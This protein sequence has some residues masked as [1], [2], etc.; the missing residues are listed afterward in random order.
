M[1]V[2]AR[3]AGRP[4]DL[5]AGNRTA[6]VV[7]RL[8]YVGRVHL[9]SAIEHGGGVIPPSGKWLQDLGLDL[10]VA[11]GTQVVGHLDAGAMH[12]TPWGMVHGGVY[13]TIVETVASVGASLAVLDRGQFAVG[14]HNSTDFLRP[15]REGRIEVVAAP[16]LQGRVQQLW[17]VTIT[18]SSDGRAVA[19]GRLR[20]QN[21][22]LPATDP[23]VA[24]AGADSAGSGTTTA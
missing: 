4:S 22:P 7:V 6:A 14:V 12:H 20:L 13:A 23:S 17:E 11:T 10:D 5:A 18:R 19:L 15:I 9:V 24:A 21:V 16:L 3:P 8:T 2:G 1:R